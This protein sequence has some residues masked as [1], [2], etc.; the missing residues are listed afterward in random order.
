M[1][2]RN[3]AFLAFA[4]WLHR[5]REQRLPFA[6]L[7]TKSLDELTAFQGDFDFIYDPAAFQ[8]IVEAALQACIAHGAAAM[9]EQTSPY[10][11]RIHF[12]TDHPDEAILAELWPHAELRKPDDRN[13]V[14][15]VPWRELAPFATPEGELP[16]A[17]LGLLYVGHLHHKRKDLQAVEVVNRLRALEGS[18]AAQDDEGAVRTAE[19]LVLLRNEPPDLQAAQRQAV[20][21]LGERGVR[22][23]PLSRL[24]PDRIRRGLARRVRRPTR[25]SVVPVVGPDG[26][27][28]TALIGTVE[29]L[30]AASGLRVG[31]FV[32]KSTFRDAIPVRLLLR[33]ARRRDQHTHDRTKR[34]LLEE[35]HPHVVLGSALVRWPRVRAGLQQGSYR[36]TQ[37]VLVDRYFWDYLF[38]LRDAETAVRPIR[39]HRAYAAILPRP[40]RAVILGCSTA[41]IHERK[42]ELSAEAIDILYRSYCRHVAVRRVP[43][44][45]LLST[46]VDL[47]TSGARVVRFLHG[48]LE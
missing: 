3:A 12:I 25:T 30:A 35:R 17:I 45:L 33:A 15:A 46:E 31:H 36:A 24:S 48:T 41:V 11:R 32:F 14:C 44:T 6:Q 40:E 39:A 9:V 22:I 18:L 10:K 43:K 38:R 1:P 28:K 27:G 42:Q 20:A 23:R 47:P 34:N 26:V 29:T 21:A 5:L 16:D 8:R 19:I 2:D 7:R 37:V 13:R 4:D